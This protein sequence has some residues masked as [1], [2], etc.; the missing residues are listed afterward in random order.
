M[1]EYFNDLITRRRQVTDKWK[2]HLS[3]LDEEMT[4]RCERS[5]KTLIDISGQQ[6]ISSF[7]IFASPSADIQEGD[8]IIFGRIGSGEDPAGYPVIRIDH[9]NGWEASHLEVLI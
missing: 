3:D 9:M 4:V 7:R 8:K 2:R 6:K 5:I 1:F